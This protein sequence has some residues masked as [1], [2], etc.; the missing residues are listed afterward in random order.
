MRW[1]VVVV[2]AAAAVLVSA[3]PSLARQC[4]IGQPCGRSCIEWADQCTKEV[5]DGPPTCVVGKACG[6]TCINQYFTC[7]V[8]GSDEV[9]AQKETSA[10]AM[11]LEGIC[12]VY[13]GGGAL[14]IAVMIV[15]F[16]IQSS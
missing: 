5:E 14:L 10:P 3:T 9:T 1:S 13:G 15:L 16:A 12:C 6:D 7:H 11:S 8:D 2:V 4:Q